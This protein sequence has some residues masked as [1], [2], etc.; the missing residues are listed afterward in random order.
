MTRNPSKFIWY[1]MITPDLK[2]AAAFYSPVA[3]WRIEDSGMPGGAYSILWA[4]DI[5]VGGLMEEKQAAQV[6]PKWNG[7]IYSPGVDDDAKRV[8]TLGGRICQEPADI[9][10]IGRFAVAADPHGATFNLFKPNSSETPAK[11]AAGTPGHIGWRE[12]HA[13][14]GPQAWTFY[15]TMFGW[16]KD[17]GL[18]MGAMGIYQIFAAGDGAIGA[19]M[20]K[21][22]DMPQPIWLYY[23]NVDGIDAAIARIEKHGGKVTMGPHEV[24]TKQ[25]IVQGTDP[26]GAMFALL[27]NTK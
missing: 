5:M 20:T 13:G 1:D 25:W 14:D 12:L 4:G 8:K 9:P 17:Q 24:P 16:T 11:V 7:Y 27:S 6:P 26:Q 23:F 22:K 19:M 21:T 18:D 2:A 3:G 10:G 15:E